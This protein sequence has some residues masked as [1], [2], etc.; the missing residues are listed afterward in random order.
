MLKKRHQSRKGPV[1]SHYREMPL[2][3]PHI[4]ANVQH[5]EEALPDDEV[6]LNVG[7]LRYGQSHRLQVDLNPILFAGDSGSANHMPPTFPLCSFTAC[8]ALSKSSNLH[9]LTKC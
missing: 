8:P 3:Q 2:E 5:A 4:A 9:L 7:I 1:R 6:L